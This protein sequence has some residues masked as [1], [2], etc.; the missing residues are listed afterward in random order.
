M[1]SNEL[2][3][4]NR[5]QRVLVPQ[6][7]W[8]GWVNQLRGKPDVGS[9]RT[10]CCTDDWKVATLDESLCVKSEGVFQGVRNLLDVPVR[11]FFVFNPGVASP[12]GL[13]LEHLDWGQRCEFARRECV[14]PLF[15]LPDLLGGNGFEVGLEVGTSEVNQGQWPV[16]ETARVIHWC[17]HPELFQKILSFLLRDATHCGSL[18]STEHFA[19][20][21]V[22]QDGIA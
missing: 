18:F 13:K 2:A 17:G 21:L 16:V 5:D 20:D 22:G 11:C 6:V 12:P 8:N 4:P 15:V 7:L 9:L 10:Q 14:G 3:C 1:A 19:V